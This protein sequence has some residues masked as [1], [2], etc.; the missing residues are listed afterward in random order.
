MFHSVDMIDRLIVH[1]ADFGFQV[2][3]YHMNQSSIWRHIFKT[4]QYDS[5]F[6]YKPK[7][8]YH[9]QYSGARE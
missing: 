9:T 4:I 5:K 2:D 1:M 6:L 8:A 3:S 7:H